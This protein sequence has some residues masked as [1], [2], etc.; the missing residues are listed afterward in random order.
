[1]R[2]NLKLPIMKVEEYI[3]KAYRLLFYYII[4]FHTK[5]IKLKDEDEY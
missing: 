1:M 2:Y 4:F 3:E 5:T